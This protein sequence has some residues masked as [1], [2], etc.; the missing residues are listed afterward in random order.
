M[1]MK[2]MGRH[3][4]DMYPSMPPENKVIHPEV[5]LPKELFEE[6]YNLDDKKHCQIEFIGEIIGMEHHGYRVKVLKA[7]EKECDYKE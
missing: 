7:D 1:A 6:E 4:E 3:L 5:T 2:D